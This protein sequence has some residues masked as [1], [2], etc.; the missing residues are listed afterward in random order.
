MPAHMTR[1][2]FPLAA[3]ALLACGGKDKAAPPTA[4]D[5]LADVAAAK[6]LPPEVYVSPVSGFDLSLPGVWKGRYRALE[7]SDTTD[8]GRTTVDFKFLPDSGS[9]APSQNALTIRIFSR[10]AWQA[11]EKRTGRPFGARIAERGDDVF[12]IF[13]PESNPYPP[14]SPEAPVFDRLI[15]S[16]SLGGQQ[17]HLTPR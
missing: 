6:T 7:R 5:A 12:L 2:V 14:G 9:K 10:A 16:L 15:I 11:M 1:I 8:G 4:E 17:V 13:L 3:A